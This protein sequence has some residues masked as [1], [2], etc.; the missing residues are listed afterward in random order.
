MRKT[1]AL[2]LLLLATTLVGR[3][4]R[5]AAQDAPA[6]LGKEI[7]LTPRMQYFKRVKLF[8]FHETDDGNYERQPMHWEQLNGPGLPAFGRGA[9]DHAVGHTAPPSFRLTTPLESVAFEYVYPDLDVIPGADYRLIGYV[10]AEGVQTARAF[11]SAFFVDRFGQPLADTKRVSRLIQSVGGGNPEPWQRI[12]MNLRGRFPEAYALRLRVWL[13]QSHN[14]RLARASAIDP[15]VVQD[16]N[17]QVW[18][19]D[20]ALYRLPRAELRFSEPSG[21]LLADERGAIIAKVHNATDQDLAARLSV[22]DVHGQLVHQGELAI[23]ANASQPHEEPLPQLPAGEYEARLIL[24]TKET[25]LLER[26]LRFVVLNPLAPIDTTRSDVCIDIG[27]QRIYD[28]HQLLPLITRLEAGA[29]RIGIPVIGPLD[30]PVK[31]QYFGELSLLVRQLI[32]KR[33]GVAAVL[34]TP[35]A[36][37]DPDL[38]T[39]TR[40]MLAHDPGWR[41]RLRP[42]LAKHMGGLIATWQLGAEPTE[43][44]SLPWTAEMVADIRTEMERFISLPD[45]VLPVSVLNPNRPPDGTLSY[46]IPRA[47]PTRDL[48]S[49]LDAFA[50]QSD[51]PRWLNLEAGDYTG[52][53]FDQQVTDFARR[54]VIAKAMD[55]DRLVIPAPLE[56]AQNSGTHRWQPRRGYSAIRTLCHYLAGKRAVGAMRLANDGIAI[57]FD[58]PTDSCVIA[59]TWSDFARRL[60]IAKAMDPDR[61]V[62]PAPLELA[63][64]S[65]THRWQPRRGYSAIRTLCH[66]LA[67]KRAVGA[68][69]LANDG[70]AIVFD[71]PTDSCV[72]AWTWSDQPADVPAQIYLGD[73]PEVIDLWGAARPATVKNGRA[74]L[75]LTPTP[76]I[77]S[78]VDAPLALVQMSFRIDPTYVQIHDMRPQPVVSFRNHYDQ[79]LRGQLRFI[80]P[81]GWDIVPGQRRFDVPPAQAFELPIDIVVPNREIAA[82]Q[83]VGV[84]VELRDPHPATLSFSVPITVGLK[85][86]YSEAVARWDGDALVI[87]H[88]LTNLADQ[89]ISFQGFCQVPLRPRGTTAFLEILPGEKRIARYVFTGTDLRDLV[90]MDVHLRILEVQGDRE[91]DQLVSIPS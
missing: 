39:P 28:P 75:H 56:L 88:A 13:L 47:I 77:L 8:D 2:T 14:W 48:P 49:Y 4:P 57:V 23:A 38:A 85:D 68:M 63:Q 87:E 64:N 81:P 50:R 45:V 60:V 66:Y 22:S 84:E 90:G 53:A 34:L 30:T 21:T 82:T 62:I 25:D 32:G 41:D 36:A 24:A 11:I 44:S 59:W 19:D 78:D 40:R 26:T 55:P 5:A 67:G 46:W 20:I 42:I 3:P 1:C 79:S 65:G 61:L 58:G 15:I 72:I 43:T 91:L 52:V 33:L 70:I 86:I 12:E 6:Q 74:L 37:S 80:P 31:Q 51:Q 73:Q 29:V 89:P 35:S 54:L 10:K 69:R 7:G 17:P 16:V 27:T 71:G 18:F 9:F 83:R 76:M